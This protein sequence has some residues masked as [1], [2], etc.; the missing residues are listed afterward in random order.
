MITEVLYDPEPVIGLPAKEYIE[1]FNA[2]HDTVDLYNWTIRVGTKKTSLPR[3]L[4]SPESFVVLVPES[5]AEVFSYL[6]INVLSPDKW[7]VLRNS[8]QFI[9]LLSPD[10]N[11]I[12]FVQYHPSLFDDIL[13]K[14]GGWSLELNDYRYPC[15][16]KSWMP[17]FDYSGGTPGRK[18]S[19]FCKIDET[20]PPRPLRLGILD[21]NKLILVLDNPVLP[22]RDDGWF[23]FDIEPFNS[24]SSWSYYNDYPWILEIV[25]KE[26]LT[27]GKIFTLSVSGEATDC[28]GND[29]EDQILE[30][31]LPEDPLAGEVVISE[32]L[33]DPHENQSE[34]VCIH[35]RSG[36]ILALNDLYISTC[37]DTGDVVSFSKPDEES[38]LMFP[39]MEYVLT[40]DAF[41][42]KSMSDQD[43]HGR[44]CERN[45]FPSLPNRG[46]GICLMDKKQQILDRVCYDPDWHNNELGESKGFSLERISLVNDGSISSNWHTASL[47]SGGSTPGMPN[48]QCST[49]HDDSDLFGIENQ[50]FCP[51][52]DGYGSFLL[53][54]ISTG[55]PGWTGSACVWDLSGNLVKELSQPSMLPVKG[56]IKWDGY[57]EFGKKVPLAYYAVIINFIRPDGSKGRWKEACVVQ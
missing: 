5:G 52:Q 32:I 30:F 2:S 28:A 12:H 51:D 13:K 33:F 15:A 27:E 34:F 53:I 6:N 44:I 8:G 19:G 37:D 36:K 29:L 54:N 4:L 46:S 25:L 55:E 47:I 40:S 31:G 22:L 9:A 11:I 10:E 7:S 41:L 23:Q 20:H 26:F 56:Q 14:E 3:F 57:D 48:S 43:S 16:Q 50:I 24:V 39:G 18:N 21:Y 17:S 49:S 35:N 38:F 45:D 42:V 1:L